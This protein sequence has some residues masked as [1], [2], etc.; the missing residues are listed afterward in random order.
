M[1]TV[2]RMGPLGIG[3]LCVDHPLCPT[4]PGVLL[5]LHPPPCIPSL[6]RRCCSRLLED[7]DGYVLY[8]VLILKKFKES[9]VNDARNKKFPVREFVYNPEAAGSGIAKLHKMEHEVQESLV[10]WWCLVCV[11]R[12]VPACVF[13]LWSCGA[14]PL[15][16]TVRSKIRRFHVHLDALE[17]LRSSHDV[18]LRRV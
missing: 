14:V 8:T 17:G 3:S 7:K 6:I 18:I 5:C 4:L 16:R 15:A 10:R 12:A 11:N 2:S 1:R 9:F 13:T